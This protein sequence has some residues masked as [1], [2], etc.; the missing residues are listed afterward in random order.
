MKLNDIFETIHSYNYIENI[1]NSTKKIDEKI[2]EELNID[3]LLLTEGVKGVNAIVKKWANEYNLKYE[4]VLKIWERAEKKAGKG[5]YPLIVHIFKR[6]FTSLKNVDARTVKTR[7]GGN[8][9]Y[10]VRTKQSIE[11]AKMDSKDKKE[12]KKLK[13]QNSKLIKQIKDLTM[14][15]RKLKSANPTE[16]RKERI[17]TLL[18]KKKEL[19]QEKAKIKEQMAK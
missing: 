15:I 13:K 7:T 11:M 10:K 4:D 17:K 19:Q 12:L 18:A 5:N 3:L 14:K 6:M 16:K 2:D 8:F 9:N 1:L